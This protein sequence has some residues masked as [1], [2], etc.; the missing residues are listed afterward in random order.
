MPEGMTFGE[1]FNEDVRPVQIKGPEGGT[2]IYQFYLTDG[3][4]RRGVNIPHA[5]SNLSKLGEDEL[6]KKFGS[7]DVK[8]VDYKHGSLKNLQGGRRELWPVLLLLLFIVL[9]FEMILA[10]GIPFLKKENPVGQDEEDRY[11]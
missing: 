7:I 2:G 5:E 8:V 3:E 6:R 9:A 10:N 11:T 1:P 4:M